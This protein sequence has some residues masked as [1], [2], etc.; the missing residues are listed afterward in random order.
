M[1]TRSIP[2]VVAVVAAG[3]CLVPLGAQSPAPVAMAPALQAGPTDP[4][5]LE[6]FL[7]GTMAA[8]LDAL[9]IAGATTSVVRNG[10]LL[11]AKGYGFS[12]VERRTRVGADTTLFRIG[13]ISKLFVWTAVM[14]MVE[15]GQLDLD[16]D[17]N[18]YLGDL[19]VPATYPRP[20]TPRS[21]MT[22]TP[23]FEEHVLGLFGRDASTLR[24]LGRLLADEMPL[25]VR[26]PDEVASYSNHGTGLAAYIVERRSGLSWDD[27]VESRIL[28]PLGMARTTFR[29]PLPDG[30]PAQISAG[31]RF[32]GGEFHERPFEF[33]PLAPVGAA[34]TTATDMASFMIAHLQRGRFGEARILAESTAATMQSAVFRHAPEV[35]PMA[36][37]FIDMSANG[38]RIIGHGGDTLWFHSMLA[39]WPEHGLGFFVSFN[40]DR[41][42]EASGRVLRAFTNHYFPADDPPALTPAA[43][44]A[45]RLAR[46]EGVYR[47]ARYS[48]TDFTKIAAALQ[49]L[50]IVATPEG[51]L[52]TLGTEALRWVQ[53]GPLAFRERHGLRTIAFREDTRGQ[54]A[55][56]FLGTLPV[57]AFERVGPA[58]LPQ[59]QLVL[60]V[61]PMAIFVA[62]IVF[63][64]A[65]AIAR[66]HYRVTLAEAARVPRGA[67]LLGWLAAAAYIAAS[68]G[69]LVGLGDPN[70]VVFG[71]P[72]ALGAG[73]ALCGVA[74][75]LALATVLAT[76][77]IWSLRRGSVWGR[78]GYTMLALALVTTTWQAWHWNLIGLP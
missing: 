43:D 51:E 59:V 21:L 68:A 33:V 57:I 7:D 30:F 23:G 2:I 4:A 39:L 53:T 35:N 48:H 36:H 16:A 27:Y 75:I 49:S 11:L 9:H 14:Q 26:P 47:P 77:W 15:Q 73:L 20:V 74:A 69:L 5:E 42:G 60:L 46:F 54:I 28:K 1:H 38:Q 13:S 55:Y 78:L 12:D 45:P 19:V 72:P 67:R 34:S 61:A 76:G 66:R 50:R 37:G 3:L 32:A 56:L 6:A 24:P 40:S 58:D 17:V 22:H 63:W 29:Q 41:G 64:P 31:Y 65:A 70:E 62:T 71:L 8:M 52:K 10:G 44:A 25:R 18:T